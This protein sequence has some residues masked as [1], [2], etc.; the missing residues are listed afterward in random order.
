MKWFLFNAVTIENSQ[1]VRFPCYILPSFVSFAFISWQDVGRIRPL[2]KSAKRFLS[3]LALGIMFVYRTA[4]EF[5][6][7]CMT[8][9]STEIAFPLHTLGR[10]FSACLHFVTP[11]RQCTS[12]LLSWRISSLAVT[13]IFIA[14]GNYKSSCDELEPFSSGG[15]TLPATQRSKL[16]WDRGYVPNVSGLHIKFT[17]NI[18]S[19]D[20]FIRDVALC[21]PRWFLWVIYLQ[22]ILEL[23]L[24][25]RSFVHC[26][27]ISLTHFLRCRGGEETGARWS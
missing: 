6:F 3:L 10:L 5:P 24:Q 17:H 20:F 14:C 11:L 8:H 19:N 23:Q 12:P 13:N 22:L 1:I 7:P 4:N 21:L 18:Q 16:D 25:Q 2:H 27:R 9:A 26:S 15:L